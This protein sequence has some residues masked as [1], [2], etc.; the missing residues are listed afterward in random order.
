MT[1]TPHLSFPLRIV[2]RRFAVVEQDS[3][4]HV[5]ECVEAAVRTERGWRIEAPDFGIPDY[6]L[7]AGG[8]EL[9]EL[10][11]AVLDSEPRAAAV[12]ELISSFDDLRAES[13]R[14]LIEEEY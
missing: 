9:H 1:E 14:I 3:S 5:G 8:V 2:G 4:Q 7:A 10:R 13:V 12:V 6:V 11:S